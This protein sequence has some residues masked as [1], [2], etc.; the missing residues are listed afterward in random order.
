[1]AKD[2]ELI[3]DIMDTDS[4]LICVNTLDDQEKVAD[5]ARNTTCSPSPLLT[6]RRD[7]SA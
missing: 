2:N 4:Q 3:R 5:I 6:T 7:S 1:M